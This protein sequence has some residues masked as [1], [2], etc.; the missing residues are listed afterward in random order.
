MAS[1]TSVRSVSIHDSSSLIMS[2]SVLLIL[3]F[4]LTRFQDDPTTNGDGLVKVVYKINGTQIPETGKARK[5][6]SSSIKSKVL[7]RVF[8]EDYDRQKKRKIL[9]PR[10]PVIRKWNK[11]FLVACLVSLFVDPLFFY[12]PEVHQDVC[13][14][15]RMRLEAILTVIRTLADAFYIVQ[16]YIRF[17]TAYVAPSSRVFGRGELI[18]DTKKIVLRYLKTGFFIDLIAALPLPQILIWGIIP[19]LGGSTM[20]NTK[21]VLR[22]IL[23]C[24]YVPRLVLIYPLSSE[25]VKATGVVT[26]TAWAG[27]AYN[28]MLFCLLRDRRV[29]GEVVVI[30]RLV[31]ANMGS[32]TAAR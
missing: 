19:H 31:L 27:A 14:D 28:L 12:L 10:G 29:A 3:G 18:I 8:S 21:N 30:S 24:Q 22:F 5:S 17:H 11:I 32:S 9:D 25:I 23:I 26:E 7:S 1:S 6:P 20:A 16:I 4:I 13:I 15:I 2:D